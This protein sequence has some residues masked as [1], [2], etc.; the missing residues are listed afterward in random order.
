MNN[1]NSD[2]AHAKTISA[3]CIFVLGCLLVAGL[4]PFHV[5]RNAVS[6]LKDENGLRF[7]RHGSAVS[8]SEFHSARPSNDTGSSLEIWLTPTKT[9]GG[10]AI[11]A[12]DSSP[13]PWAPFVLRQYGSSLAVQRSL[14]KERGK[15]TRSWFQV[16]HVFGAGQ[17]VF[18]TIASN[19]N[20]TN[21]YVNGVLAATSEE[22]GILSRELTGHLVLANSTVDDSWTGEIAGLAIYDRELTLAQVRNHFQGWAPDHGPLL[23]GE[24]SPVALYLFNERAGSTV[25]NLVDSATDLNVPPKYFVLHPGFLRSTWNA[26]FHTRQVWHRWSFWKNLLVNIGGFVPVGLVFFIYF[27]SVRRTGRPALLVVLLGLFLS[28]TIEALQ[29][30]L[31]NRD[32]GMADLFTN[33]TGTAIGVLLHR[34]A[35]VRALWTKSLEFLE[36]FWRSRSEHSIL[37]S[38]PHMQEEKLIF[39]MTLEDLYPEQLLRSGEARMSKCHI[40]II[41]AGPYGLSVAAHLK[42]AGVDFRIFGS[43]MHTWIT[44]M[45]RGMRLKSEGFASS[46]YDPESSFTLGHY[47]R[48]RGLSY[49]DIGKP[50]PLERFIDYGLEFQK[51]FAPELEN[52]LIVSVER[53]DAGFRIVLNDGEEVAAGKIVIAVGISH[54]GYVPPILSLPGEF[55]THSSRHSALDRFKGQEVAVVGAGASALDLAALLHEAGA[56]VQLVARKPAIRFHDPPDAKPRTFL[57]RVR[58]PITG[59]GAGWKLYFCAYAPWAFHHLPEQ[60][61]LA[62]VKKILGPAPGWFIKEQVVG[63]VPFHLGTD[64]ADASVHNGKVHLEL[65]NGDARR[66]TLVVDHV[67]AATGYKVDL[68]RLKFLASGVQSGLRSVEQS[69]V[70]SSNFESSIPGLDFVGTSAVKSFGPL[71]RFAYGAG[72]TARRLST[73]LAKSPLRKVAWGKSAAS[74]QAMDR[75]EVSAG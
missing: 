75:D 7:G 49:A 52:K 64:I 56:A 34:S 44:Q 69:P 19:K 60:Y 21:F 3:L 53:M 61:R 70:L 35:T 50:V 1:A 29:R 12:F 37:E 43:P 16:P 22:P 15:V 47:C 2:S 71:M 14:V 23:T 4:W 48:E 65:A 8:A 54:F 28:F 30:L 59:I 58:S 24:Q 62:G 39:S 18:V 20:N 13:D 31:P 66:K 9:N 40:A 45:P 32:S 57:E 38:R 55:V 72:F 26:D 10:G 41:G 74:V 42:A 63:K 17:R 27:S 25:H 5:P 68:R 51:R 36:P 73:H 33:T 11:L 67:I 46:L 6:W